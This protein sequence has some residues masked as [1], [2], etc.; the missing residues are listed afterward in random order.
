MKKLL[1]AFGLFI[2]AGFGSHSAF[3]VEKKITFVKPANNSKITNPVNVCLKAEGLIVEPA[4]NGVNEGKGHHHVFFHSLPIDLTKPIGET[5]YHW[6][7]GRTCH[8]YFLSPG[9]H[10][11]SALFANG[12]H[13]SFTPPISAKIMITVKKPF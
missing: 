9:K 7:D 10:V 6:G 1:I 4:A 12:K 2:F 3:A 5:E 13:I 8:T 11:I